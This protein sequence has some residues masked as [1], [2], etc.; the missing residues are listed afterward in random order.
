MID[1]R[2]ID[3]V[4]GKLKRLD[5]EVAG[6]Q[7]TRWFGEEVYS[8]GDSAVLSSGRRLPSGDGSFLRGEGIAVVLR[9]RALRAWRDGGSQWAPVSPRLAV[10]RLRFVSGRSRKLV[11][12]HVIACYA[13][14]FRA[15][16]S[17][18]GQL[19]QRSAT[20]DTGC[21]WRRQVRSSRRLQRQS[22]FPSIWNC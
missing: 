2:R 5:I 12:L 15:K 20:R 8:V 3:V 19:L 7:E 10:A 1:D 9:G 13:P 16:R 22:W 17:A 11:N 21:A 6:L 18:K 4:V 14:T